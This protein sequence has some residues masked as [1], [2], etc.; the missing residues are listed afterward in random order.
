MKS[1]FAIGLAVASLALLGLAGCSSG[2]SSDTATEDSD[3]SASTPAETEDG[4]E[5]ADD[6]VAVTSLTTAD[7]DLGTIVVDGDGMTVYQFDNDTQ[8]T[9]T[10]A[11][12]G[13]CLDNWP[14]V[15]AGDELP[16]LDGVTGE[17]GEIDTPDGESQLTLNGW[18]LYYFAG[19]Q[20]AGDVNGQG[21]S[22][23]WWVLSP[24]GEPITG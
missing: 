22:D 15:Y 21:V 4:D 24:A 12:T 23:V 2:G 11:C 16:S 19:D 18:P 8:G 9:D 13:Q 7:S 17:L 5:G 1:R 10:S 14:P 20:A 6:D 3:M